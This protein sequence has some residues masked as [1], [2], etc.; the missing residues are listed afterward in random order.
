[1]VTSDPTGDIFPLFLKDVEDENGKVKTR[2][3]NMESQ[4][5]RMVFFDSLQYLNHEDMAAAK[6]YLKKPEDFDFRR[7]LEW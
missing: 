5:S 6:K 2:M 4:K 1:M 3:V 7:I